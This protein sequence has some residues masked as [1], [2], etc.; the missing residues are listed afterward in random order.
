MTKPSYTRAEILSWLDGK[1]EAEL[2]EC[3][4]WCQPEPWKHI[5]HYELLRLRTPQQWRTT[6]LRCPVVLDKEGYDAGH[7]TDSCP[8]PPPLEGSLADMAFWARDCLIEHMNG[9]QW[10]VE[11]MRLTASHVAPSRPCRY[12]TPLEWCVAAALVLAGK[13]E[14]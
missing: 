4:R 1:H 13:E 12:A 7:F 14:K 9:W 11:L 3:L 6:C 2:R 8:V 5:E 10:T